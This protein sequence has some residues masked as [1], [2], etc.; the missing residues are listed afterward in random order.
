MALPET[1][2]QCWACA[3]F[4]TCSDAEFVGT[5]STIC[6]AECK[7][8]QGLPSCWRVQKGFF[9]CVSTTRILTL[10]WF[11]SCIYWHSYINVSPKLETTLRFAEGDLF[12]PIG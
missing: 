1:V 3:G 6:T 10:K 8:V 9:Y 4:R 2:E 11:A 12:F 7:A 5:C